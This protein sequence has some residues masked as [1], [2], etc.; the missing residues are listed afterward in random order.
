MAL[1]LPLDALKR[2]VDR[3]YVVA[4]SSR[5]LL[6]GLAVHVKDQDLAL[7][8]GEVAAHRGAERFD[9]L[10][11]DDQLSGI[12]GS[13]WGREVVGDRGRIVIPVSGGVERH[14]RIQRVMFVSVGALDGSQYLS[15]DAELGERPKRGRLAEVEVPDGLEEPDHAL[16]DDVLSFRARQEVAARLGTSEVPVA[17]EQDLDRSLLAVPG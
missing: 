15:R 12:T 5:Y 17:G 7:E 2:I 13:S 6:V 3:L 16:L 10:G 11:R 8:F 9:L 1:E 4:E 14:R